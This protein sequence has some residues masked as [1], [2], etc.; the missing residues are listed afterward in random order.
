MLRRVNMVLFGLLVIA[1]T[2]MTLTA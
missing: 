1:I 2:A